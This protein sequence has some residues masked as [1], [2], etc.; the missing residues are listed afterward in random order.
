MD[1]FAAWRVFVTVVEQ[2]GFTAAANKLGLTASAVTKNI[3]QLEQ[4]L[5]VR[6]LARTTRQLSLTSEGNTFF[7]RCRLILANI[8]Q[9][10]RE[11][12]QLST[13][14]RGDLHVQLSPVLCRLHLIPKLLAF[15]QLYPDISLRLTQTDRRLDLIKH[16]IDVAIWTGDLP[17]TRMVARRLARS[18][19]ITCAAPAYI[20]AHGRPEAPEDLAG[21]N[22]LRVTSWHGGRTWLFRM[23]EGERT[24]AIDGNLLFDNSDSYRDAA[25]AGLGVAQATSFLFS[26]DVASG[27]LVQ[28]LPDFVAEGQTFWVVYPDIHSKTPKVQAFID[29]LD[30]IFQ[31][32]R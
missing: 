12:S 3:A 8:E 7:E 13:A 15:Q 19:R 9:A 16:G 6:L 22:C 23:P 14:P 27:D 24:V 26:P 28:L 2:N 4:Q 32:F 30:G 21:H 29:L 10:E 20:A 31:P 1:K 25:L 5:N 11:M 17:D 18:Q